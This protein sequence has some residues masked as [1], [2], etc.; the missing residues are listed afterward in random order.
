M[1]EQ[2]SIKTGEDCL[3]KLDELLKLL[4]KARR[5]SFFCIQY[6]DLIFDPLVRIDLKKAEKF[7]Y[8]VRAALHSFRSS[9][10]D[11][12]VF[13]SDMTRRRCHIE[14]IDK[15]FDIVWVAPAILIENNMDFIKNRL[16]IVEDARETVQCLL[17]QSGCVLTAE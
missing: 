11:D 5:K 6:L 14:A 1:L 9:L 17:D 13:Y 8:G 2:K 15:F 4:K 10:E 16:E 12:G 7:A 3:A